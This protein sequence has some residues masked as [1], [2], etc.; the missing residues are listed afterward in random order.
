M[1]HVPIGRIIG[2]DLDHCKHVDAPQGIFPLIAARGQF[3]TSTYFRMLV[4]CHACVAI[5]EENTTENSWL[6]IVGRGLHRI[7]G[8]FRGYS[9]GMFS[10]EAHTHECA[11]GR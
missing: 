10:A 2:E 3:V 5:C 6:L 7:V 11:A 1:P 4:F 9:S 8:Y